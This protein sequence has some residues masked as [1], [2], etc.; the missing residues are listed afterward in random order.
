LITFSILLNNLF[1]VKGFSLK[2]SIPIERACSL[3]VWSALAKIIF[4]LYSL[5]FSKISLVALIPN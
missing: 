3:I 5:E 1:R 2:L 4:G